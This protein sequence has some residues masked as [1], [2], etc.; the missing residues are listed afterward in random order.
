MNK[1]DSFEILVNIRGFFLSFLTEREK[2]R[3]MRERRRERKGDE[4]WRD[5]YGEIEKE[6]KKRKRYR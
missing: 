6:E 2:K 3:D 4:S 1:E 5:G